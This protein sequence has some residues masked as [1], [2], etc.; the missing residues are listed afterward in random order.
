MKYIRSFETANGYQTVKILL[1]LPNV[2]FVRETREYKYMAYKKQK[3]NEIFAKYNI[4][5]VNSEITLFNI[6]DGSTASQI[7][8][9]IK[10]DEIE[11]SKITNTYQFDTTGEHTVKYTLI[12]Y[13]IINDSL[14]KDCSSLTSII[15][16][17]LVISIGQNAFY[18]CSSLA[19]ITCKAMTAPAITS[20]TFRDVK[21]SGTLTVPA[22]STGYGTW[23]ST[24]NYYL[25]MYGWT[26]VEQ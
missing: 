6:P 15:I 8:S 3:S 7:F 19:S 12:D 14:F 13:T 10:I 9:S 17:D 23:M 4:N 24:G 16:P 22:G 26:K 18:G 1:D 11:L 25:G 21:T 5:S 2:S 20:Y